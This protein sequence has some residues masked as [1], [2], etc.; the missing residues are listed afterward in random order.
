MCVLD[1]IARI[2][3]PVVFNALYS[4]FVVTSPHLIWYGIASLL[5]AA[6]LLSF[7]V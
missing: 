1:S 2:I 7:G 5:G 6:C 4:I 3:S